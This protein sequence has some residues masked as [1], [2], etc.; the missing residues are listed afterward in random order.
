VEAFAS[1]ALAARRSL[2]VSDNSLGS[3][4]EQDLARA[5]RAG[6]RRDLWNRLLTT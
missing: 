2:T 6:G 5:A 3:G 4:V 1:E